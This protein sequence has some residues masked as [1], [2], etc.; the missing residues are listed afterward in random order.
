MTSG[1]MCYEITCCHKLQKT[2]KPVCLQTALVS[3]VCPFWLWIVLCRL[4]VE[5]ELVASQGWYCFIEG[6]V[7]TVSVMR[8]HLMSF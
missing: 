7:N 2:V 3:R 4:K 8:L 6:I 5:V 1:R